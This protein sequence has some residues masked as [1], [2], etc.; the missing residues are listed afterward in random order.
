[1]RRLGVGL[2]VACT[3]ARAASAHE[4]PRGDVVPVLGPLPRALAG[5]T[6]ELR[7]TLADQLVVENRTGS[8]LEV[9]ADDGVPFLRIGP[10]GAE[11][12]SDAGG[13]DDPC[14]P[15]WV[16][17][18]AEP[19]WGWFDR[20]LRA[21]GVVVPAATRAAGRAATV[22][23]WTIPLRLAG[24]PVAL[25]G[26]Y[27]YAPPPRGAYRPRLTSTSEPL[28]GVRVSLVAGRVPALYLENASAAEP[29][30]VM[31]AAGE[32]FLR[33]APDGTSANVLSPTWQ[34][35]GKAERAARPPRV[36]A[37]A[38]PVWR[39]VSSAPRYAWIEHRATPAGDGAPPGGGRGVVGRWDVPLRRGAERGAVRGVVEWVPAARAAD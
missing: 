26:E 22:G 39:L 5:V 37:T 35:S 34:R 19:A 38:E 23:T 20:R 32:P 2:L 18:T 21:E 16:R 8:P 11:A 29:V 14:D 36:D 9:L 15:R 27:R 1:M 25:H 6:V 12:A 4:A 24:A 13:K 33:V 17:V 7:H 31:G 3:L 10:T 28:P 30:V